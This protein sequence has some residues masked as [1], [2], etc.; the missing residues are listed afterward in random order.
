MYDEGLA[1]GLRE[2][3]KDAPQEL[4]FSAGVLMGRYLSSIVFVT[5]PLAV[6][7]RIR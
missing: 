2:L 5:Q 4:L 7:L 6:L 1:V 3:G